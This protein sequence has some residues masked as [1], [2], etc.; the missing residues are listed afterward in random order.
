MVKYVL[1][2]T[3]WSACSAMHVPPN[4]IQK[5]KQKN[6]HDVDEMP[7]ESADLDGC[8]VAFGNHAAVHPPCHHR[9]HAQPDHHVQRVQPGHHEIEREE[10]LRVAEFA[11]VVKLKIASGNVVLQIF[12]VVFERL[13]AEK[14]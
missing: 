13:D 8:V 11:G 9:H 10:Q 6:P 5:R 2:G 12:R 7:I 1:L 3:M 14:H 4:Q